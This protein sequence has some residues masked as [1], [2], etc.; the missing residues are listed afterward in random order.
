[1]IIKFLIDVNN[2][3]LENYSRLHKIEFTLNLSTRVLKYHYTNLK[4]FVSHHFDLNNTITVCYNM[5]GQKMLA[6]LDILNQKY[7]F[8][9]RSDGTILHASTYRTATDRNGNPPL[10]SS[11]V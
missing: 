9:R 8:R 4:T 7:S 2:D 10:C 6:H 1:M 11:S 3:F 5:R